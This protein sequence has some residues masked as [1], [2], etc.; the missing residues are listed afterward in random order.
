MNREQTTGKMYR[1]NL[2]R[3]QIRKK[4]PFTLDRLA[5]EIRK[6]GD[7]PFIMTIPIGGGRNGK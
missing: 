3:N 5:G 6:L 7:T 4:Y 1:W 2:Y